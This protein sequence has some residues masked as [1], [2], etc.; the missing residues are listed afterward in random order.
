LAALPALVFGGWS[1]Y[2]L[3]YTL[4][5]WPPAASLVAALAIVAG[6]VS[7]LPA[8]ALGRLVRRLLR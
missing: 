5:D 6:F 7:D 1:A 3:C 8:G 2:D 4:P